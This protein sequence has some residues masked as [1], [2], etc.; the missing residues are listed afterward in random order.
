MSA[1]ATIGLKTG[2]TL[3]TWGGAFQGALGN[4][5]ITPNILSPTQIGSDTDWAYVGNTAYCTHAR[6][7][8][9]E[10]FGTG[11]NYEYELGLDH[12]NQVN[13]FTQIGSD[14]DWVKLFGNWTAMIAVK[15]SGVAYGTGYTWEDLFGVGESVDNYE[16][17][18]IAIADVEEGTPDIWTKFST[19][20][21]NHYLGIR[22]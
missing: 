7:T 8:N 13:T 19:W 12:Q 1:Y 21:S 22:Q 20:G 11:Y 18:F 6:K 14:T 9:G 2:G 3:F 10:M 17:E 16:H 4:G 5:T 15:T